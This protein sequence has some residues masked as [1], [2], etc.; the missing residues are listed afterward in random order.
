MLMLVHNGNHCVYCWLL[1][2]LFTCFGHL[3]ETTNEA[4][5]A[6]DRDALLQ[7][8]GRGQLNDTRYFTFVYF[9]DSFSLKSASWLVGCSVLFVLAALELSFDSERQL[10]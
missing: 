8:G 7:V 9:Y 3:F 4:N 2:T 1:V 6:M 10:I 5:Q